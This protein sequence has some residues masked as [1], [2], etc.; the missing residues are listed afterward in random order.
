MSRK[1]VHDQ[2]N[3]FFLLFTQSC[4]THSTITKHCSHVTYLTKDCDD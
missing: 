3:G 1:G 2:L 4:K